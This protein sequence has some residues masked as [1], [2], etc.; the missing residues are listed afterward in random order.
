MAKKHFQGYK[1]K[2]SA[3]IIATGVTAGVISLAIIGGTV[4]NKI[5]NRPTPEHPYN[6]SYVSD[7]NNNNFVQEPNIDME[8][9]YDDFTP[10]PILPELNQPIIPDNNDNNE[11]LGVEFVEVLAKLTNRSKDYIT[12]VTGT[13]PNL[14][15][16]GLTSMNINSNKNEIVLLGQVKV[17]D[18]FNHFIAT[19]S[20]IN[21]GL[22]IYSLSGGEISETE[23]INAL[24]ELVSSESTDFKLQL[25]QYIS[26]SNATSVINNILQSRL[27]ELKALNS[28]DKAV[29]DEISHLNNLLKNSEN[30]KLNVLLNSRQTD[31][32]YN[33]SFNI[34]VNTGKHVYLS[35]L[36]VGSNRVLTTSALKHTIEEYLSV[37]TD[38]AVNSITSTSINNAL[39]LISNTAFDLE[40]DTT[41]NQ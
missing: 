8:A 30:L 12:S 4:A 1:G 5:I 19:M 7:N 17:G 6:D 20:N 29:L 9:G 34:S 38:Y 36:E 35:D 25:K 33:Y 22:K 26:L 23:F 2:T 32:G 21:N 24:D 13:T 14:T 37:N 39:Y 28:T 16:S 15:I 31:N 27:G 11:E 41:L 3:K 40:N 18:N 10:D